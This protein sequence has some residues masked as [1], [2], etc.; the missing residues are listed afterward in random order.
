MAQKRM[1]TWKKILLIIVLVFVAGFIALYA[2]MS[3]V[4]RKSDSLPR[5]DV[6]LT[7]VVDGIYEGSADNG[8]V[9]VDVTVTVTDH[10]LTA[11]DIT[12]HREGRGEKAEAITADMIEQNAVDVDSIS[13]ATMSSEV[14][15]SAVY[16]ALTKP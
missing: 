9:A 15:K 11:I 12:R 13:G 6:D 10:Q 8:L 5:G 4:I 14:I 16:N 1:K 3:S 2:F 7:Q